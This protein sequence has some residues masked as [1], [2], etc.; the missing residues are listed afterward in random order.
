MT[1]AIERLPVEVFDII[2]SDL[3]LPAYKELRLSS[4]TLHLL[5]L[6]TFAK[7]YFSVLTT[8]LGSPSLDR[9]LHV[10]CH[11]YFS[12]FVARLEIKLLTHRDYKTLKSIR[13]VGI[14]PPPKRLQI[15]PG[16]RLEDVSD[17]STLYDDVL[18]PNYPRCI[19][20]RLTRA[21]YG[22]DNLKIARFRAHHSEHAGR[23]A[24]PMPEGD[25]IFRTRCFQAV[26]ESLS[27]SEVQLEEFS[28]AKR[29]RSCTPKKFADL[30][31]SA[32]QL[33]LGAL[34]PLRHCF[35][36]L[37]SLTLSIVAARNGDARVPGWE[38]GMSNFICCASNL[39]CL[40]LSLDRRGWSSVYSSTI[41]HSL[42]QSCH[43]P[44]LESF[45]LINSCLQENDLIKFLTAHASTI[46]SITLSEIRL[47]TWDWTTFWTSLRTL[48]NLRRIRLAGLGGVHIPWTQQ[49]G[50]KW[51]RD[52]DRQG[53]PMGELLDELL[54]RT[55]WPPAL[56]DHDLE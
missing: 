13:R 18:G 52:A 28:M 16:I 34:V 25:Q 4:R 41:I 9:L 39:K 40:T 3:D 20:D 12:E 27:K 8:T 49:K 42:A 22:F 44:A 47:L 19:I 21:L 17:E 31:Y 23:Q 54:D 45:H 29:K 35:E 53:R 5:S 38:N 55:D 51:T 24:M 15:V 37:Q 26:M 36:H 30:P 10:S 1:S 6:S 2:T 11:S 14:Y 48:E 33:S 32:L 50:A 56:L 7:R 43:L 46:R